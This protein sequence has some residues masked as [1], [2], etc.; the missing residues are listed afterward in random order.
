MPLT[1]Y[2]GTPKTAASIQIP[3]ANTPFNPDAVN[4]ALCATWN[5][6]KALE[7]Y[8]ILSSEFYQVQPPYPNGS[9][10]YV[11][12]ATV[13]ISGGIVLA[14]A[15]THITFSSSRTFARPVDTAPERNPDSWW[16]AAEQE[17]TTPRPAWKQRYS[18]LAVN[19]ARWLT[20]VVRIP[21][22]ATLVRVDVQV[23]AEVGSHPGGLPATMP[24]VSLWK[25]TTSNQSLMTSIASTTDPSLSV[26]AYETPH[27][28]TIT[29][30]YSAITD[31]DYFV[32][33]VAGEEGVDATAAASY[34]DLA[35]IVYPPRVTWTQTQL[36]EDG[37]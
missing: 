35:L 36:A 12:S 34:T 30:N 33:G 14:G 17:A 32:I 20:W 4:P 7:T 23:Y 11:N 29:S 10:P 21:R 9:G 15:G 24:K 5:A 28:V 37:A 16:A 13:Y 8:G 18:P 19:P 3:A 1:T 6:V 27:N 31:N 26:A 2:V 22:G 25:C